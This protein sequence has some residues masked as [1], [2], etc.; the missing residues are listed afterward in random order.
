MTGD[1]LR[2]ARTA[3]GQLWG[4]NRPVHAAE[5]GRALRMAKGDPGESIRSYEA[6]RT[7]LVPGPVAV[8]VE[9]LLRG[10]LPPDGL[11]IAKPK[12]R[13]RRARRQS[14]TPAA[15]AAGSASR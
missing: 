7:K 11:P 15:G 5:L 6:N 9:L 2:K 1:D 8:V 13:R 3:I 12:A 14:P 4:L 10:S